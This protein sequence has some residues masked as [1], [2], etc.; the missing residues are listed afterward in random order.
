MNNSPVPCI[1]CITLGICK[2]ILQENKK[3]NADLGYNLGLLSLTKKC[4]LLRTFFF[5]VSQESTRNEA[6]NILGVSLPIT[7]WY[8]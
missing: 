5:Q 7:I 4:S 6:F 8:V 3:R 1:E 2:S